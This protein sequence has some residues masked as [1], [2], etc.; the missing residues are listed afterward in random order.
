MINMQ[1]EKVWSERT[2][3]GD[4][5]EIVRTASGWRVLFAGFSRSANRSLAAAV[6]EAT[7]I[8]RDAEWIAELARALEWESPRPAGVELTSVWTKTAAGA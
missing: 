1:D 6:A 7:G 3:M 2:P 8:D 4:T 5:L